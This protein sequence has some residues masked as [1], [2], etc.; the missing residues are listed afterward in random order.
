MNEKLVYVVMGVDVIAAKRLIAVKTKEEDAEKLVNDLYQ[1]YNNSEWETFYY[2][3]MALDESD[4][5]IFE[6]ENENE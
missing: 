1:I 2:Q 3:A 5:I 4:D 6:K